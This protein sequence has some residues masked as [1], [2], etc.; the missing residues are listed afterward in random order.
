MTRSGRARDEGHVLTTRAGVQLTT[1][2]GAED[3]Q[4]RLKFL[5]TVWTARQMCFDIRPQVMQVGSRRYLLG[6]A[7]Q[8][9]TATFAVHRFILM[10]DENAVYKFA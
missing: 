10:A 1:S 5:G 3:A 2:F 9:A 7:F 8:L 4:Q 6:E